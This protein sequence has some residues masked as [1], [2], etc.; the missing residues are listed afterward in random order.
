MKGKHIMAAALA[1]L[2]LAG[3]GGKADSYRKCNQAFQEIS[4]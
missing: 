2:L 1:S 4:Y 3:C